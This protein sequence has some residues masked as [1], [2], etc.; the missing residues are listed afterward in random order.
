MR[1]LWR[2]FNEYDFQIIIYV[3]KPTVN[4]NCDSYFLRNVLNQ[5]KI[6]KFNDSIQNKAA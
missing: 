5:H 4:V 1:I 3:I 6:Y 2:M